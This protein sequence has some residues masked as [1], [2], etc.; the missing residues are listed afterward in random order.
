M[1]VTLAE[2]VQQFANTAINAQ[3]VAMAIS[4]KTAKSHTTKKKDAVRT[5]IVVETVL[6]TRVHLSAIIVTSAKNVVNVENATVAK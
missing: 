4:A 1:N 3:N 2:P 5:A 6:K